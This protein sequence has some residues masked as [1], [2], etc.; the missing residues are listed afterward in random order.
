MSDL[1]P[2]NATPQER[3]LSNVAARV[4]D[5]PVPI[6]DMWNADTCPSNALAW[7]AWAFSVDQWDSNWTDAQQRAFIKSSVEVHRY[8][9]TIGAV[10]DALAALGLSAQV[11]EWFA[12]EPAGDPYTFRILVEAE[13]VGIPQGALAAIFEV[14]NRTKNLRSHLSEVQVAVNSPAGPMLA[15]VAGVGSEI[16]LSNFYWALTI[17]SENTICI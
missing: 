11:Q 16:V 17:C 7:L 1:L 12:Q 9:G 3:A 14:V 6:R 15:V 10:R 13:Q 2:P 4:S 5:V 8:K